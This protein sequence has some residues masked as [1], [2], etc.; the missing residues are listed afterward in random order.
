LAP[1]LQDSFDARAGLQAY[2]R[3]K[4]TPPQS[5][6]DVKNHP[7][8]YD[9]EFD[10]TTFRYL[11]GGDVGRYQL[12][13]SKQWLR[14]GSWLAQPRDM[15]LFS[16]ERVL[17]REITGKYPRSIISTCAKET[18]LN[19]KSIVNIVKKDNDSDIV[20]LCALLN[21]K[22]MSF[23]HSRRS[24]KANRSIFPKVVVEDVKNFPVFVPK[25]EKRE[26]IKSEVLPLL[27]HVKALNELD[28]AFLSLI[29]VDFPPIRRTEKLATWHK[30]G[31]SEL[32]LELEK[33]GKKF[34]LPQKA[35]WLSYHLEQI[36]A[37]SVIHASIET[38]EAK[39]DQKINEIYELSADEITLLNNI[40]HSDTP[41]GRTNSE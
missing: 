18:Y 20:Y 30:L 35:E 5:S 29:E 14:W 15:S 3:G 6:E 16:G 25:I 21:S 38:A 39:I 28:E 23:F 1:R 11:N 41:K 13:W 37:R 40:P 17:V 4:G 8:D 27:N 31:F 26:A 32:V 10:E 7:F 2:E 12:N 9:H 24:V 19:N 33:Q 22:L 36:K 34:S